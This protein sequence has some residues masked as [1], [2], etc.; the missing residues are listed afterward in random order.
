MAPGSEAP[1]AE[2]RACA[3]RRGSAAGEVSLGF[4]SSALRWHFAKRD[5]MVVLVS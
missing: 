4:S 3:A 2:A 1:R 5:A